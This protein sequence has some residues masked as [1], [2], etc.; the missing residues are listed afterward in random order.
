MDTYK[1]VKEFL[2]K[3]KE[4]IYITTISTELT[5][6]HNTVKL[7]LEELETKFDEKG[8]VSLC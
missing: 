7:I 8:R 6:N 4:P 5:I 3:Q 2:E 1:K